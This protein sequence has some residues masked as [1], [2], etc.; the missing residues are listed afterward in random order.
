MQVNVPDDARVEVQV[1]V[2]AHARASVRERARNPKICARSIG[3]AKEETRKR[4]DVHR[5]TIKP[6]DLRFHPLL[7]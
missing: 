2:L 5:L 3:Y 1:R 4:S 7:S 6:R